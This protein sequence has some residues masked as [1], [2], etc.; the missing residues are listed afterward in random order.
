[1]DFFGR[2]SEINDLM[3]LW[4]KRSGSLVTCRGRRRIGKST[5]IEVFANRSKARF[6]RIEGVRPKPEYSNQTELKTFARELAAQTRAE[7]S[8]PDNWLKAFIRLDRE[9]NDGERTVVLLDEAS[10][11]G[12]YD[13]TFADLV[14]I[15]WDGY[16]S[17]SCPLRRWR[18][19]MRSW[20][21]SSRTSC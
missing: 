4:S 16:W 17:G 2:E 3:A 13:E 1:M 19:G 7:D 8:V 5:L 6:I 10:W 12:H 21:F 18:A 11:L 9:I 14:K 15:A 20:D